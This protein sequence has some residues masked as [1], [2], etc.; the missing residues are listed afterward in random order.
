MHPI[1]WYNFNAPFNTVTKG[2]KLMHNY[3]TDDELA[4]MNPDEAN[5]NDLNT[6]TFKHKNGVVKVMKLNGLGFEP[7]T[8]IS[9]FALLARL[10]FKNNYNEAISYIR[11]DLLEEQNPYIRVRCDYF[12]VITKQDRYG[13]DQTE[14]IAWKKDEIKQDNAKNF[15]NSIPLFDEFI[16]EPNNKEYQ[17]IIRNCYNHYAKFPHLPYSDTVTEQD[18][19]VTWNF[20]NHIFVSGTPEK[21]DLDIGLNYLKCLYEHP[22]QILPILCLISRQRSTGKTT[23]NNWLGMIFG[24]NYV[25]IS[26][27]ALMKQFNSN[28]ATKNIIT[29]EEA[30]IEK[31]AGIEKLK[32]LST[33]K[34]IDV[35]QKFVS[36]YS[37]PF[38]GKFILFSNKVLDF[39]R[40]DDDE[41]RFWIRPVPVIDGKRNVLIEE[42]LYDEIP[43][44]L[45]YLEQLPP[46]DFDNGSRMFIHEERLHNES[47]Q[48]VKD[49]SRSGLYKELEML[50]NDF[51]NNNPQQEYLKLTSLDIK[52]RWFNHDSKISRSYIF[53]TLKNDLGAIPTKMQKYTPF[54]DSILVPSKKTGCPFV[55]VNPH[56]GKAEEVPDL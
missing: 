8:L 5:P 56:F 19:P 14:L 40:I 6:A 46:L 11:A 34:M 15:I 20:L 54:E 24:N 25:S 1:D 7:N 12:K 48:A 38:Y 36:E 17:P 55:F 43:K 45:R 4:V 42:Q 23:F 31:Q 13:S 21:P 53:K 10:R 22:K 28:Y 41:I 35:S 33:A 51:F 49:E 27:E 37:I 2:L 39:M 16:I 3:I 30:F 26:P 52:E 32:S 29:F 44:F 9:K 18:I 47:L 50:I